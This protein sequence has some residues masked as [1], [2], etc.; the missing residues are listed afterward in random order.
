MNCYENLQVNFVLPRLPA[1][2]GDLD[3]Q[4]NLPSSL[5]GPHIR[6]KVSGASICFSLL[7]GRHRLRPC[8]R[9]SEYPSKIHNSAS[10]PRRK[11][12]MD[13][14]TSEPEMEDRNSGLFRPIA[15]DHVQDPLDQWAQ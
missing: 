1:G 8:T 9:C 15:A 7:M 6:K 13:N 10:I 12:K 5:D 4:L 3:F 14:A 2:T 11:V